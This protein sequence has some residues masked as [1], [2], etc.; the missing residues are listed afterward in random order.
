M[1]IYAYTAKKYL[2]LSAF[3]LFSMVVM[4]AVFAAT[5]DAAN[6][7][8]YASWLV[9][10]YVAGLSMIMLPCTMP[11]VFIIVPMSMGKGRFRGPLMAL[12][13]GTGL[14]ITITAYGAGVGV[15]GG[16]T[17]LD[18]ASLYMFIIAGIAAFVFG[19]SQI[20]LIRLQLPSYSGT[21]RFI[22]NRGEY[23]KALFMGLLLGNAGVGCP[24]PLF[25]WL[26]IYVAGTGSAEAGA[27]L[28][29]IHG[30]GRA[31]PLILVAI[32]AIIGI[33]TSRTLTANRLHIEHASGW[34]LIILGSFLIINGI[35]G[36]H[37]W[38]E[39]TIIHMGWNRIAD[40]MS[41]PSEFHMDAHTHA[42][43]TLIPPQAA[44]ALLALMISVPVGWY[45]VRKAIS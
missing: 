40:M 22:Q 24:N 1:V 10:S 26:L 6:D 27:G 17:G 21:P 44:P 19:L 8:S 15:L 45:F 3:A 28:G 20:G 43:G 25:Y 31:V 14:T 29:A 5:Y 7:E 34:M 30:I 13:F 37:Q 11:L 42:G 39:D 36:G 23:A 9:I 4:G 2:T 32:L 41:L 12:L 16:T 38:Y 33:N 35:P 18:A